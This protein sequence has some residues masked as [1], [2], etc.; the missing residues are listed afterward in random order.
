MSVLKIF[1]NNAWRE[2]YVDPTV[3]PASTP[4]FAPGEVDYVI[5]TGTA[6][7]IVLSQAYRSGSWAAPTYS[8]D[9]L[10]SGVTLSGR[11]LSIHSATPAIGQSKFVVTATYSDGV[12]TTKDYSITIY[13]TP[14]GTLPSGPPGTP[15]PPSSGPTPT[16]PTPAPSAAITNIRI[17]AYRYWNRGVW[18]A[19]HIQLY[20]T[21]PADSTKSN[22]LFTVNVFA[23]AYTLS[24]SN[25]GEYRQFGMASGR[26]ITLDGNGV[27][28]GD[29][30]T[31]RARSG[32]YSNN[33]L[34]L[35]QSWS[36]EGTYTYV[37]PPRG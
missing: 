32:P 30:I 19:S 26:W 25:Q 6:Q 37:V 28:I 35:H 9:Y 36:W 8:I 24:G 21:A 22:L 16:D 7:T 23:N 18:K 4:Q 13:G 11:T 29:T 2:Y 15:S 34:A 14:V 20:Y 27:D 17:N 3:T 33:Y 1:N 10:P 31:I 12:T 5:K